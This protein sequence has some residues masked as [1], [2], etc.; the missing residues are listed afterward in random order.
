LFAIAPGVSRK[1]TVGIAAVVVALVVA[2]GLAVHRRNSRGAPRYVTAAVTVGPVARSITATGTVNPETTVQVGSYV[3][4][5]IETLS[6]DF[7][8]AVKKGQLCAKIDPRPYQSVVDQDRA[9]VNA[10][11]AQQQKDE[12]ALQYAQLTYQ[13]NLEL[14]QRGIVPQ[15][16]ADQSKTAADQAQAQVN[17]DK[18]TVTQRQAA[19]EAAETNLGYTDIVS[20]VDGT[21][22]SRNVTIGQTVAASFQTPTLFLIATDLTKMQVD[23]NVSESDI[24]DVHAG[25]RATFSVEAFPDRTFAGHV[26]QVRQAPQSVQNVVTYDAVIGVDNPDQALKPGMTAT[27]HVITAE[28]DDALRVPDQALRYVPGGIAS[29]GRQGGGS[30]AERAVGTSGSGATGAPGRT[31]GHV[32]V[33]RNGQPVQVRVTVGLDDDMN[34]EIVD[35]DI[36]AGDQVIVSE[37]G[38]SSSSSNRPAAAQQPRLR[39]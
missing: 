35:G 38:G 7:N 37:Q 16:T 17:L 33:L 1:R 11:I 6:C 23:T 31:E 15:D 39:F 27:V 25:G 24:G 12:T 29:A 4:G 34:A 21:V 20:P 10:A 32:W 13:R 3:S 36:R 9:N 26:T 18:T 19:L 30:P 8:T 22:V 5:V 28:R 2:A 14:S